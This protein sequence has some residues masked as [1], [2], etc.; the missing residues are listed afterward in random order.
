MFY[1]LFVTIVKSVVSLFSFFTHLSFVQRKASD[2]F[3]LILYPVTLM[4]LFVSCINS[5]VELLGSL[6][7]IIISSVWLF[8]ERSVKALIAGKKCEECLG[9]YLI[10]TAGQSNAKLHVLIGKI[11]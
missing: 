8:L 9:H 2:L 1:M 3:E 6:M 7:Y 5:L 4:T 11:C 10:S